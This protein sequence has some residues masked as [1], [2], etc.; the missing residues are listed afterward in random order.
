MNNDYHN[1]RNVAYG[2]KWPSTGLLHL[3]LSED[4]LLIV[5]NTAHFIVRN[6]V[7]IL[8]I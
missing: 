6:Y 2:K 8:K 1:K 4:E 5:I 7:E 3:I